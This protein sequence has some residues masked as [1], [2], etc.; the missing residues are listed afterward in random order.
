M[1]VQQQAAW[2]LVLRRRRKGLYVC[3]PH[4]P[5]SERPCHEMVPPSSLCYELPMEKRY[6]VFVSSTYVDLVEERRE[7]IQALLEL[8]C[9][10]AA[11]EMF[12]AADDD[13]WTLIRRVIDE[14]DYYIVV[15]GGRYGSLGDEGISYTEREYDYAVS[16]GKP[17]LGFVHGAPDSIPAGRLDREAAAIQKLEKFRTKVRSRLVREFTSPS[18][19]GSVVS[20]S[21]IRLMRDKPG[22]GWVRGRYAMSAEVQ[23]EIA[24][25]KEHV[26]RYE[27]DRLVSQASAPAIPTDGLAQGDDP[28][29]LDYVVYDSGE[30]QELH[31]SWE[32][33]WNEILSI[34]A[35]MMFDEAPEARMRE[36]L[37]A[38]LVSQ[39]RQDHPT[40]MLMRI[41][42]HIGS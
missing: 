36:R 28:V 12:P 39:L 1:H 32:Y 19:L 7:I 6:Q 14:S 30:Y 37:E 15:V 9:L 17:V 4:L 20:R 38:D 27:V 40:E 23:A 11:M 21:L 8:D 13:Q 31:G 5:A 16:I 2:A 41:G 22:E 24:E 33:T 26:A 25:L 34:L 18:D 10:P 42:L 3:E 35:P 29:E